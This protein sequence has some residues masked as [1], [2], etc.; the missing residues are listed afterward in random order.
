MGVAFFAS[1]SNGV[2]VENPRFIKKYE[3]EL[4]VEQRSLSRKIKGSNNWHKQKKKVQKVHAKIT[5]SRKDFLHK[6]SS[7]MPNKKSPQIVGLGPPMFF[8]RQT[9]VRIN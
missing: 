5:R 3:R 6:N 1:L 9:V 8:S 2:Q 7:G 4:R